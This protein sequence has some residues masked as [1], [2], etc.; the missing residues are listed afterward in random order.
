M[1]PLLLTLALA[2]SIPVVESKEFPAEAQRAAVT[3]TV[4]I[5][6]TAGVGS[7]AVIGRDR[8]FVYVLTAAHVVGKDEA[9][10][11]ATFS[12]DSYPKPARAYKEAKVVAR[13]REQD[14]A[15]LRLPDDG[16]LP[17]GLRVGPKAPADKA[18]PALSV[19]CGAGEAPTCRVERVRSRRQVQRPGE[20]EP[21]WTWEVADA[22][23]V[24]RSGGPLLDAKGNL[25]GVCSGVGDGSGYYLHL[26]EI[27][28]FL[29]VN[30][31]DHLYKEEK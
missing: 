26:D 12:A 17:V 23:K 16:K 2:D 3:A 18:F 29:R 20:K 28:R 15:L 4:R 7:G 9:V 14:L 13:S 6:G 19:G 22:P 21:V 24:G 30:V 8:V 25:L 11:V 1:G 27:H 31:F 10:E 5:T